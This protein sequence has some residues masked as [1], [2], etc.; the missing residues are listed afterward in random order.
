MTLMNSRLPDHDSATDPQLV[1]ARVLEW[2]TWIGIAAL[3]F[4]FVAYCAGW[5]KPMV[6][7]EAMPALWGHPVAD[8]LQRSG[9]PTGW[10]WLAFVVHGDVANLVGI[11]ILA[12]VSLLCLLAL[13]PL[14]VARKD[15]IYALIAA[16]G[17]AVLVLAASSLLGH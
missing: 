14:Y 8:Y 15:W 11:G 4:A 6:P 17:G 3:T 16:S 10:G 2:G 12:G 9:L 1:Y 5:L 13:I 7:L